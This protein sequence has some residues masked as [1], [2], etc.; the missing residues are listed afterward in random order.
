M[1]LS[2]LLQR[3]MDAVHPMGWLIGLVIIPGMVGFTLMFLL[4]QLIG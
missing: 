2:R 1:L 3:Y 4:T